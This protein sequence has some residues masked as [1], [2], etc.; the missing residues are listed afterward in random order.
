MAAVVVGCGQHDPVLERV[1]GGPLPEASAIPDHPI[2]PCDVAAVI[3]SVC[4]RCHSDMPEQRALTGPFILSTWADTQ[5]TY[6]AK[7]VWQRMR[8]AIATNFMPLMA[9]PQL[10][11]PVRPLTPEQKDTMLGWLDAGA[12]PE[13]G[14]EVRCQ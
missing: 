6:L 13:D 4:H 5:Q 9:D 7:P 11:P 3:G 8:E 2:L 14:D 12:V 1:G 10:S